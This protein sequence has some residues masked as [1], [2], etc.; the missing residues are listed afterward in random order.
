MCGIAGF[1]NTGKVNQPKHVLNAMLTRIRHRGPDEC[2]LYLTDN[3]CVGSVRLS[4]VDLESGQQPL[5]TPDGRYWIAYNGEVYNHPELRSMLQKKG[6]VSLPVAT[7]KW[8]Y[9]CT[10]NM[11]QMV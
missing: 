5:S 2:G 1:I 8:F 6:I 9:T 10:K 4:I 3:A 11:V 7:P